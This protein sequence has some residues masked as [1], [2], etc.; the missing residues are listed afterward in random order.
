MLADSIENSISDDPLA[1]L[2][3]MPGGC[4][5]QNL[6]TISLP[7]IAALYLERTSGWESVGVGKKAEALRYIKRGERPTASQLVLRIIFQEKT[8]IQTCK[9]LNF[10]KFPQID[11][12]G[13]SFFVFSGYENQLAYR[14]PDG[15]YPPYRGEGAST[16]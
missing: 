12:R 16:W 9:Q 4:V 3:Q 11:S 8:N 1:R 14:K 10:A 6:A 13:L 15:S 7:L 2:I 5:E